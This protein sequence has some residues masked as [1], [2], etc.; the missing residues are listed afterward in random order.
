M[1]DILVLTDFSQEA[2]FALDF[3]LD[4]SKKSEATVHVVHIAELPLTAMDTAYDSPDRSPQDY[5]AKVKGN[6]EAK[7]KSLVESIEED[8]I[9]TTHCE[10]GVFIDASLEYITDA[11]IDLVV[12]GR[13]GSSGIQSLLIGS[14]AEKLMRSAE[15]PV[16]TINSPTRAIDIGKI[17]FGY[18]GSEKAS[19]VI[20]QV[21][22]LQA[23]LDANLVLVY[24]NDP[25]SKDEE[26]EILGKMTE[27]CREHNLNSQVALQ[28]DTSV[29]DGLLNFANDNNANLLALAKRNQTTLER[30]FSKSVSEKILNKSPFA[31]WTLNTG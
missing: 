20:E 12:M 7:L 16:I 8:V 11:G 28:Y 31:I 18:H 6:A 2:R 5:L 10:T 23:S 3:A 21:K 1:T 9:T 29:S 22:D 19:L 17:V 27:F 13:T 25:A 15:C 24:V 30:F 26:D 4:L 14:S